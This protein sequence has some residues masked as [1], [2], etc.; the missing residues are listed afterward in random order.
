MSTEQLELGLRL[1][2]MALIGLPALVWWFEMRLLSV[3]ALAVVYVAPEHIM[4]YL[5][6]RR[7]TLLRVTNWY[8]PYKA[9]PTQLKPV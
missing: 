4:Q 3:L 2:C 6:Q 1:W 9:W 5:I 7:R 8:Q